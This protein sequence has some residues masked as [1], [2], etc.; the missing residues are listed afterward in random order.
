MLNKTKSLCENKSFAKQKR[1]NIGKGH[2]N[3]QL[4]R[5]TIAVHT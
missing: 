3:K 2:R 1:I 4:K 5:N